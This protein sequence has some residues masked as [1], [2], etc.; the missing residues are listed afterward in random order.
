[1][2]TI[3]SHEEI[4]TKPTTFHRAALSSPSLRDPKLRSHVSGVCS[5]PRF[6]TSIS[7]GATWRNPCDQRE[8]PMRGNAAGRKRTTN[9]CHIRSCWRIVL[10]WW[11]SEL[12]W[13][14]QQLCKNCFWLSPTINGDDRCYTT[15]HFSVQPQRQENCR[16]RNQ[17]HTSRILSLLLFGTVVLWVVHDDGENLCQVLGILSLLSWWDYNQ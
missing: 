11:F 6:C 14:H 12:C 3:Q 1:M 8:R 10:T 13:H 15:Y 7:R 2:G 16:N 9:R 17:S 4:H 5:R